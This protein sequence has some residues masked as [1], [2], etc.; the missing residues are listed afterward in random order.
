ML[1][2][3]IQIGSDC[4]LLDP[5]RTGPSPSPLKEGG[6]PHVVV[7]WRPRE[8]E[9]GIAVEE[10]GSEVQRRVSSNPRSLV[11]SL[12]APSLF[13]SLA[14][15]VSPGEEKMSFGLPA[16]G[17]QAMLKEGHKHLP[18][19]DEAVLRNIDAWKQL[20]YITRT[21]LGPNGGF[22]ASISLRSQFPSFP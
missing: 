16:Y 4:N 14:V 12:L 8:R 7:T 3:C 20:S 6:R 21:S 22:P 11:P 18:G 13:F 19:L 1:T 15:S 10:F 9:R 2:Y 17:L 5:T